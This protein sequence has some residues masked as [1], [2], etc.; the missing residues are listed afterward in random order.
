MTEFTITD[1]S[2]QDV[3]IKMKSEI[4]IGVV[5]QQH[6]HNPKQLGFDIFECILN[7]DLDRL[8]SIIFDI[9]DITGR[10]FIDIATDQGIPQKD[11]FP[12][13]NQIWK[14]CTEKKILLYLGV[15]CF[16][17]S[18][19][20]Y[21]NIVFKDGTV[22]Q[23]RVCPA[24]EIHLKKTIDFF[25]TVYKKYS[26]INFFLPFYRY[27]P[28][29][30]GI[31]CFC[32]NCRKKWN[33]LYHSDYLKIDV[34]NDFG[35]FNKWQDMRIENMYSFIKNLKE[36]TDFYIAPEIDIDPTRGLLEGILLND[37][38][39]ISKINPFVD[40]YII[41]FYDKS[42]YAVLLKDA[43]TQNGMI[44]SYSFFR[45]LYRN[46]KKYSLFY[47]NN[48]LEYEEYIFKYRIAE[49]IQADTVFYLVNSK[50]VNNI[51]KLLRR[52]G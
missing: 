8:S 51:N 39:D 29:S 52:E 20:D 28:L 18:I 24:S 25:K 12:Y 21:D 14:L 6:Y 2:L 46:Q 4:K 49:K 32:S 45:E 48:G 1:I 36:E 13:F 35:L 26:N 15:P 22:M 10:L 42:G 47:W 37:C 16:H 44:N 11:F 34:S 43:E 27:P 50:Q 31:S 5:L 40:E 41:H 33:D 38:Q 17:N 30:R 7:L 19:I 23:G 9:R 3:S